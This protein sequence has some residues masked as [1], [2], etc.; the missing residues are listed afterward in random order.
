MQ[1]N[2]KFRQKYESVMQ[3][4]ELELFV[5]PEEELRMQ[6]SIED[7][8]LKLEFAGFHRKIGEF[9]SKFHEKRENSG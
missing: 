2:I 1:I 3:P 8:A 4:D 7:A 9:P 6:R 5:T